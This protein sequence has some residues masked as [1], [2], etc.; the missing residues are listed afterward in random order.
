MG[1]FL[2]KG[3]KIWDWHYDKD[4]KRVYHIKGQTMDIYT[5]ST[6]PLYANQPNCWTQSQL[7]VPHEELGDIC[8]VQNAALAVYSVVSSSAGPPTLAPPTDFWRVVEGWG[9]TWMWDNLTLRGDVSWLVES[10]TD[11]SLVAVTDGS[12]M[13]DMYPQLNSATFVFECTKGRGRL[14]LEPLCVLLGNNK[15]VSDKGERVWFW[16]HQQ[17][18]RTRFHESDSLYAHQ[19]DMDDWEMMHTALHQVPWMFQIWACKQ[20]MDVALANGNCPWE[21]SLCPLCQ[22][23]TQVLE[24]CAHILFCINEGWVDTM[25]K[26]IDLLSSWMMEVNTDPD[27]RECIVEYAKG[28]GT[29]TML[30]ICRGMDSWFQQMARDQDEIG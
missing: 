11:N 1:W 7:D 9:N 13:K 10:I 21:H 6:V 20:V 30:D 25:M 23:C 22:S 24:T 15:V 17:L 2:T 26:S 3:H 14:C 5:P 16:V 28:R 4:A 12:Y 29:I 18:A 19:F 8:S 27:L